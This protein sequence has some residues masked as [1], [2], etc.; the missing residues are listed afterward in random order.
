MPFD[1]RNGINPTSMCSISATSIAWSSEQ[2]DENEA[3]NSAIQSI[4]D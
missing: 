1:S 3:A 2:I 4:S